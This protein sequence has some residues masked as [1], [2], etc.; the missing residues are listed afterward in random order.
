[1]GLKQR[2]YFY[3][4]MLMDDVQQDKKMFKAYIEWFKSMRE[5]EV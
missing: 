2:F 4:L 1:M 5:E 3:V